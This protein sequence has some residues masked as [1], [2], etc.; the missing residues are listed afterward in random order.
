MAIDYCGECRHSIYSHPETL[1]NQPEE[2]LEPC[3]ECDC[4]GWEFGVAIG[5]GASYGPGDTMELPP[6]IAPE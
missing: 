5:W 6:P 4:A 1:V 3:T 2:I